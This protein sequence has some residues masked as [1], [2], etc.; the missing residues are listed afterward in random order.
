MHISSDKIS[1]QLL[2]LQVLPHRMPHP[3][4]SVLSLQL[5]H[6]S[7]VLSGFLAS[8]CL[9]SHVYG[10]FSNSISFPWKFHSFTSIYGWMEF[11]IMSIHFHNLFH[12]LMGVGADCFLATME[13]A[14]VAW[15]RKY[16]CRPQRSLS[17]CTEPYGCV[18]REVNVQCFQWLLYRFPQGCLSLHS[19]PLHRGFLS[20]DVF[21][22]ICPH[23]VSD[24]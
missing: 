22:R 19:Q 13:R 24:D 2:C 16:F 5:Y 3:L 10:I 6:I 1:S 7:G 17:T 21:S 20:P 8:P 14:V 9:G 4:Q 18:V 11:H 23:L 12:L 15:M